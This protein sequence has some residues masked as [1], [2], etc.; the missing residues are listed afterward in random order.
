[1]GLVKYPVTGAPQTGTINVVT[2]CVPNAEQTSASL[3]VTCDSN[4][5]WGNEN[6]Q[7]QCR[8]G[9]VMVN[10]ECTGRY[11][12]AYAC[13]LMCNVVKLSGKYNIFPSL[14]TQVL[15]NL[16]LSYA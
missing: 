3:M 6:P 2:E 10:D 7:C 8:E 16:F 1:M 15:I 14:T 4:G 12:Y 5:S 13:F 11:I 9:T